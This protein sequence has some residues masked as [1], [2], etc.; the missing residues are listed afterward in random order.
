MR[1]GNFAPSRAAFRRDIK[2]FYMVCVKSV[3]SVVIHQVVLHGVCEKF[4]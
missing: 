3:I 4:R 2:L 1:G